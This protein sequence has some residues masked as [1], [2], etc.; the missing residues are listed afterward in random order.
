MTS[1]SLNL[2]N[3]I[4]LVAN[5]I[6]LR[7]PDGS[8]VD[9]TNLFATQSQ[10]NSATISSNINLAKYPTNTA[11]T[12]SISS[13]ITNSTTGLINYPSSA[14][15]AT[16]LAGYT[17]KDYFALALNIKTP[18]NIFFNNSQLHDYY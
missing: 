10:L 4:D 6:S 18:K 15:L 16:T 17:Q 9:I 14:S 8:P 5:S 7:G 2:K 12:N 11:L 1:N 13:F 3:S